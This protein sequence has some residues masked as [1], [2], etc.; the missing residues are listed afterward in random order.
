VS[1]KGLWKLLK[2]TELLFVPTSD[3][4]RRRSSS[5]PS[6][7]PV[8]TPKSR[9]GSKHRSHSGTPKSRDSSPRINNEEIPL[10][11]LNSAGS[12]RCSSTVPSRSHTPS[13]LS[14]DSSNGLSIAKEALP[15]E[16]AVVSEETSFIAGEKKKE[17]GAIE[18]V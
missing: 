11:N 6:S 3:P 14:T 13:R 16:E 2:F 7:A 1:L 12:S 9:E 10:E 8:N 17:K 5:K 4:S 15:V 18:T